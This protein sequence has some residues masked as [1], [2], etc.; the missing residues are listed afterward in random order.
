MFDGGTPALKRRTVIARRRQ[1]ENAQTKIRKTAEKLLLNHLKTMRLKE[2]AADLQKQ[3]QE[4]D[5]K[6][7]RPVIPEPGNEPGEQKQD[8]GEA[9]SR[10]QEELDEMLAA[11]IA[12]EENEGFGIG[13]STSGALSD[14]V[15]Y[16]DDDEDEEMILPEMHGKVDPAVLAAL[17]PSMQLDLLV[18]MRERLMAENR[19]KYQKVKKAPERFSE[20]QIESY[21]KTV[22]FR[23]EIDGVQKSAAGRGI[24]GVQTSRIASEANREFIFSTSFTGDKQAL[25]SVGQEKNGADQ[26]QPQPVKSSANTVNN[27]QRTKNPDVA[28]GSTVVAESE[29]AFNDEVETYMDERGRFRV[30][31]VRAL[32]IR[33][34]RD[35]QRNLDLMKEMDQEKGENNEKDINESATTRNLSGVLDD[36]FHRIQQLEATNMNNDVDKTGEP[37]VVNEASIQISFEATLE[38]DEYGVNDDG[39]FARLVAGDPI[40]DY[41][42]H[43][44]MI[45][46]Q[47]LD[48]TS[49]NEWEEGVIEGKSTEYQNVDGMNDEGEVE[50]ED[51]DENQKHFPKGTLEE[52]Y[53]FQEENKT[54]KEDTMAH[55]SMDDFHENRISKGKSSEYLN[56]GDMSDEGDVEWEEGFQDIQLKSS[57]C[58]SNKAV[59]KGALEEDAALQ[60]ALRRSLEDLSGSRSMVNFRESHTSERSKGMADESTDRVFVCE[61]K[62]GSDVATPSDDVHQ[63]L[64]SM[65]NLDSIDSDEKTSAFIEINPERINLDPNSS[66]QDACESGGLAGEEH[67]ATDT[68]PGGEA[69]EQPLDTYREDSDGLSMKKLVDT[70]SEK[71]GQNRSSSV[72]P[73][74]SQDK[75]L[76]SSDA[77]HMFQAELDEVCSTEKPGKTSADDLVT[78]VDELSKNEID[79]SISMEKEVTMNAGQD[80]DILEGHL[81]EEILFLGKERE[82]LGT[83]QRRLERDAES[84]SNDMFAE[85]QELLQMFGLPYIIAPMEAEA[86]CAFMELSNLVDGV[87]TDD[88]DAFLFGAQCVYKNIF[89]ERKYVE[90]YLMKDIENELGIDR[91]KLIHMA[92][93]LGSDYTEGISGVGI[94]NAIEVVNAFH[95]KDGLREFREWI[96]SPDPSIL[97]KLDVEAGG[98]SRKKGSTDT[99]D[100]ERKKQI[101]KSKHRNVSKNWHLS[102]SFPSDAVISAYTSPQVDKS[103]EP[104]AWGKPDLFVLRKLCWEKFGWGA[105]K[106][107]ELLLPVLKEYNKHETQLRLEAFYTFNERFAKIRSKRIEKA[108]KGITGSKSSA[109]MDG[110]PQQSSGRGKKRKVKPHEDEENQLEVGSTGVDGAATSNKDNTV[111]P[112]TKKKTPRSVDGHGIFGNESHAGRRQRGRG[113]GQ[114]GRGRKKADTGTSY[115][116]SSS[117]NVEEMQSHTSEDAHQL[118]RSKRPRKNVSYNVSDEVENSDKED[119]PP[120][121]LEESI[122]SKESVVDQETGNGEKSIH[123]QLKEGGDFETGGK[124]PS[125]ETEPT[126]GVDKMDTS[127]IDD[128]QT[129]DPSDHGQDYLQFGGGFCQDEDDENGSNDRASTPTTE[130]TP[131]SNPPIAAPWPSSEDT[132]MPDNNTSRGDDYSLESTGDDPENGNAISLRAMPNLKRKRRKN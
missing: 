119:A 44:S 61:G 30:S 67:L 68:L 97:G 46:K 95:G 117:E 39:L 129:E 112:I 132:G 124:L 73:D 85:C 64:G 60:E 99:D 31:R 36:P 108:V 27:D 83:E 100:A 48:T 120:T 92:L 33:M 16:E 62:E 87:V 53:V 35:L 25:T 65:N 5:I 20:L 32:G 49:D 90:T 91:E 128:V 50:W 72:F 47:S 55:K 1:R 107:D 11:S 106:A 127:F 28:A 26:S 81:E 70:C 105:S 66:N 80:H 59:T 57:S 29:K 54:R 115:D 51:G 96:E 12:A 89:D 93:L 82:E 75:V 114:S 111:K 110:A 22:A 102:S 19:Q 34:T 84:V 38:P 121:L 17:P 7:K 14:E 43:N 40:T 86:Q 130:T 109:L 125:E 45:S 3:R 113:K 79:G 131:V 58:Q 76:G 77:K 10:Q 94:V 18:Q 78:D 4:N 122:M 8:D 24:G 2:L 42:V 71:A 123:D 126:D 37:V 69:K 101:F 41:S 21:L 98:D 104:F 56:V 103:T 63:P 118:R 74:S 116:A 6:G 88:S 23:R 9:A 52:A 13:A 15:F